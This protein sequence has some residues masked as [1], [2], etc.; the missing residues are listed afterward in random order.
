MVIRIVKLHFQEEKIQEF[1]TFFDT[2]K[3]DVA[4]FE[5]C[6]GMKL[7]KDLHHPN[8]VF[9][10]SHWHS[11]QALENY[12]TSETFT[13]IWSKIKPWFAERAEAWS[14]DEYF[15]GFKINS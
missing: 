10:Y 4:N 14:A 6:R 8:T 3:F 13:V 12:R 15:N 1:L 7:L 5:G 11:E 9:T 2:I